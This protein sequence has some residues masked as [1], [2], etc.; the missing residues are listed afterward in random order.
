M[1]ASGAAETEQKSENNAPVASGSAQNEVAFSEFYSEVN[2]A[3]VSS[4]SMSCFSRIRCI[5]MRY[6]AQLQEFERTLG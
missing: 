1:A 3:L 5:I 4:G 6:L 2:S